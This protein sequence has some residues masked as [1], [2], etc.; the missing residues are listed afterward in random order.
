MLWWLGIGWSTTHI[1][2]PCRKKN[3]GNFSQRHFVVTFRLI[4]G[5]T[6]TLH[7]SFIGRLERQ[8]RSSRSVSD[9]DASRFFNRRRRIYCSPFIPF[10]P[11]SRCLLTQTLLLPAFQIGSIPNGSTQVAQ[12]DRGI[13]T[14]SFFYK[15]SKV[16]SSFILPTSGPI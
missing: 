8:P 11:E 5:S 16:G 14:G 15:C 6:S 13:S 9:S 2:S 3:K 4:P 12:L 7:G 1:D 10:L